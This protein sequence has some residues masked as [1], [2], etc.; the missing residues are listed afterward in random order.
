MQSTLAI[1][2]CNTS[3][4]SFSTD[5]HA[6]GPGLSHDPHALGFSE[7]LGMPAPPALQGIMRKLLRHEAS[8]HMGLH[9]ITA[10]RDESRPSYTIVSGEQP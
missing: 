2:C 9:E 4:S 10:S 8:E 7:F 6:V 5:N 3:A 1:V